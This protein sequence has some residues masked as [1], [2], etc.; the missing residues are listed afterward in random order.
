MKP[1]QKLQYL[2]TLKSLVFPLFVFLLLQAKVV[3]IYAD[4]ANLAAANTTSSASTKLKVRFPLVKT[5]CKNEIEKLCPKSLGF[6]SL[7]GCF[8]ENDKSLGNSCKVELSY[9]YAN[10]KLFN[11]F[12]YKKC[13]SAFDRYCSPF[14]IE[15]LENIKIFGACLKQI[16][17]SEWTPQCTDIR[18][19]IY[20]H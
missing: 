5:N 6:S 15:N 3:T 4:N 9:F 8:S 16:P 18:N 1:Q 12:L 10:I 14:Q 7:L 11:G 13:K 20:Q 2:T 19:K 17:E